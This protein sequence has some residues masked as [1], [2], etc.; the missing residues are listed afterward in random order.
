MLKKARKST[1]FGP[2]NPL[3]GVFFQSETHLLLFIY[4]RGRLS[5]SRCSGLPSRLR[6]IG[7][8][9]SLRPFHRSV[10]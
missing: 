6:S 3:A 2:G 9:G 5:R 10:T 8:A 7:R 1:F 4:V